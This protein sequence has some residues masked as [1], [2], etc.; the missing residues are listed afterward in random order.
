VN[1]R[2]EAFPQRPPRH[3]PELTTAKIAGILPRM[4]APAVRRR[5]RP[6]ENCFEHEPHEWLRLMRKAEWFG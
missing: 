2:L 5:F 6:C 3:G 1:Y 4:F